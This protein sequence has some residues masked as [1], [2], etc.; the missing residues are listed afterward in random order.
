LE[1]VY[2]GGPALWLR[3]ADFI[4]G[5]GLPCRLPHCL[6][7]RFRRPLGWLSAIADLLVV[8]AIRHPLFFLCDYTLGVT[9]VSS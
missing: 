8:P 9:T 7:Y 3:V 1:N 5:R 2:Y 6:P 4:Q